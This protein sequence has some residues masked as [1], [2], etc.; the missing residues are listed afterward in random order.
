M[1]VA[2]SEDPAAAV[3]K[4]ANTFAEA[5]KDDDTGHSVFRVGFRYTP[6]GR[7]RTLANRLW[8]TMSGPPRDRDGSKADGLVMGYWDRPFNEAVDLMNEWLTR[9]KAT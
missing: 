4:P 6:P 1:L 8:R 2:T 7:R 5:A 3:V 9:H